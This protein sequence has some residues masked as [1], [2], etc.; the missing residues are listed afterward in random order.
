[1]VALKTGGVTK[2]LKNGKSQG[3]TIILEKPFIPYF[4][5]M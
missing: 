2:K 1:M 5:I 3:S 4:N